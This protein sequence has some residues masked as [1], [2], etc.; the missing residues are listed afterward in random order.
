WIALSVSNDNDC[1]GLSTGIPDLIDVGRSI[2]S[3]RWQ[4]R[5]YG[6]VTDDCADRRIYDDVSVIL[7]EAAVYQTIVV[8]VRVPM[9]GIDDR[10]REYPRTHPKRI[11]GVRATSQFPC[12]NIAETIE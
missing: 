4:N 6:R 11:V 9:I 8:G 3:R 7:V 12:I 5:P 10:I 2:Q 1:F